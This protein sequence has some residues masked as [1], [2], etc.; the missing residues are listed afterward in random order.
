M[1]LDMVVSLSA[2]TSRHTEGIFLTQAAGTEKDHHSTK[3]LRAA[4]Q[5][6]AGYC[7]APLGGARQKVA[8]MSTP[9]GPTGQ[10][11]FTQKKEGQANV[12]DPFCNPPARKHC[13]T[14]WL[15]PRAQLM[16]GKTLPSKE[17]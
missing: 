8:T 14:D 16:G 13:S 9:A 6:A 5:R 10:G 4:G 17:G 7:A 2:V 1:A 3:G 11:R 12:F 15:H